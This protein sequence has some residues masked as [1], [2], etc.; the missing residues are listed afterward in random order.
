M[1]NMMTIDVEDWFQ[2]KNLTGVISYQEWDLL[3]LRVKA[4]TA[5][6]LQLLDKHHTKATF[7]VLGWLAERLRDLIWD[8]AREGHEIACHGY[9]HR[10]LTSM[11]PG[12]LDAELAG[13]LAIL[14]QAS[15]QPV[16]GFRAPSFS[17]T[18]RTLWSYEIMAK[19]GIKY[20][21]SVFPI[22]FHPDYG[23]RHAPLTAYRATDAIIELPVSCA[24]V[25]GCRVPCGGGGYFRIFPYA[26]TRRLVQRCNSEGRPVV[27]YVHPW[28]FDPDQ[29]RMHLSRLK[30][31]RHYT[32][33]HRTT[34]RFD[35]LLGDFDFGSIRENLILTHELPA[36]A[37]G[38]AAPALA[39][40]ASN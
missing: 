34:T 29:P 6:V 27:F 19:H 37:S 24:Q 17:V 1:I 39:G 15:G 9:S 14:R 11:T 28:E 10:L 40:C 8:I 32:N 18:R 4:N 33:L 12:E 3:E 36:R 23:I 38:F 30:E 20:D 2:V 35:R 13:T 5:R 16:T 21:S 26:V 25:L 22:G 31:M 7:F